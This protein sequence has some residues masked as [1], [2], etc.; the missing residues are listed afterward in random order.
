MPYL[1][2]R[3]KVKDYSS[4]KSGFDDHASTRR[5][6]GSRGGHV[7]RSADDPEEVVVL[8]EWDDLDNARAF[9]ESDDLRET[10]RRVGVIGRPDVYFLEEADQPSV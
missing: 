7:F 8:L 3:H 1:L 9:A 2:V 5:E 6:S 10:M 4:W